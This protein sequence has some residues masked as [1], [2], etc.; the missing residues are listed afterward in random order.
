MKKTLI[1]TLMALTSIVIA[2]SPNELQ[3][4]AP[5]GQESYDKNNIQAQLR[6][7]IADDVEA[8]NFIRENNDPEFYTKV[9]MLKN[10]TDG[11]EI[12]PFLM[13]AINA[14]R[15]ASN[16]GSAQNNVEVIRYADGKIAVIIT[17]EDYR[18]INTGNG[19]SI[20]EL[21]ANLDKQDMTQSSGMKRI[22]YYPKYW[23]STELMTQLKTYGLAT[24]QSIELAGAPSKIGEDKDGNGLLIYLTQSEIAQLGEMLAK[25]DRPIP[26]VEIT[27]NV[28]EVDMEND[29]KLGADFQAWRN[30]D[31]ARFFSFSGRERSG[32]KINNGTGAGTGVAHTNRGSGSVNVVGFSP[33]WNTRYLDFLRSKGVAK[34]VMTGTVVVRNNKIASVTNATQI[35]YFQDGEKIPDDILPIDKNGSDTMKIYHDFESVTSLTQDLFQIDFSN[36]M[37]SEQATVIDILLSS[38]SAIGYE[39]YNSKDK[40]ARYN[41]S[42]QKTR[43]QINNNQGEF[44]LGGI[45]KVTREKG[46][47]GMPWLNEIPVLGWIFGSESGASRRYKMVTTL[48]V[49]VNQPNTQTV[50]EVV[51]NMRDIDQ[52]IVNPGETLELGF[53]QYGLDKQK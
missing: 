8:V 52:T 53:N 2:K 28:Y 17:A 27:Y 21:V 18:F 16:G 45:E 22:A 7:N 6:V 25:M 12:R 11:F 24:D 14:T 40:S 41:K 38:K 9:Y 44:M 26:E 13:T 49:K 39:S 15:G 32:W 1:C 30:G 19:Q 3:T 36:A 46:N 43:L 10:V 31:G 50:E 34:S 42:T 37:I 4:G 23:N 5:T 47:A 33:K 35:P 51:K 20:D 48:S 29:V